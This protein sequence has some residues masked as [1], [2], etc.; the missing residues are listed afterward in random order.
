M[1]RVLGFHHFAIQVRDVERVAGFYRDVLGLTEIRRW[2]RDDGVLRSIW[3]A[4]APDASSAAFL[5]VERLESGVDRS[6]GTLG[7]S[8]LALRIEAAERA[9]IER[10]LSEAGIAI[11]RR[12]PWTLY[13]QDPEGTLVGLSHHPVDAP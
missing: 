9:T 11:V 8:M 13:V 3:V 2:H 6:E 5:A 12:T 7:P 1:I 10:Q 4:L